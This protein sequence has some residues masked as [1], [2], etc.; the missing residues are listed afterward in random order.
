MEESEDMVEENEESE[1]DLDEA[2]D[3]ISEE[4]RDDTL[5]GAWK[6][7]DTLGLI[8]KSQLVEKTSKW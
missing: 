7:A 4:S 2:D 6:L 5:F 1:S 8:M 3:Q